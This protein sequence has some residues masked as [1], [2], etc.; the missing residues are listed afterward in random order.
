ML[1]DI[2]KENINISE[3]FHCSDHNLAGFS[4]RQQNVYPTIQKFLKTSCLSQNLNS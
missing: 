2:M 4:Q 1:E 3:I